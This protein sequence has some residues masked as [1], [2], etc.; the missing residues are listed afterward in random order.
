MSRKGGKK[1]SVFFALFVAPRDAS[2]TL[3]LRPKMVIL[4]L[5]PRGQQPRNAARK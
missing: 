2:E 4:S 5:L 3:H 1:V